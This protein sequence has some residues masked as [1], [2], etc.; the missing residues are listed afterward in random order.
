MILVSHTLRA[1]A[2]LHSAW[3]AA[4]AS[5]GTLVQRWSDVSKIHDDR[6][7]WAR[8]R[9]VEVCLQL[10]SLW[11]NLIGYCSCRVNMSVSDPWEVREGDPVPFPALRLLPSDQSLT[12]LVAVLQ[13]ITVHSPCSKCR[14]SSTMMD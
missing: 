3:V 11:R 13:L 2:W 14:L 9:A 8:D 12:H 10:Q 4:V 7:Q 1:R 6:Q 5:A